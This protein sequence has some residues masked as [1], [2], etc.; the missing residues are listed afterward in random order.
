[1]P[2]Q[3]GPGPSAPPAQLRLSVANQ[4]SALEPARLAVLDFLSPHGLSAATIYAVELV[5]EEILTNAIAYAFPAGGEQAVDLLV[6]VQADAVQMRFEDQ[7]VAFDPWRAVRPAAPT[8]I[9]QATP[10]GRGLLLV[11]SFARSVAYRRLHG[12]NRLTIELART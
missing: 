7:G 9:S 11:R 1:M 8:S 12:R 2:A 5:L 3:A 10:G 6:E 4:R